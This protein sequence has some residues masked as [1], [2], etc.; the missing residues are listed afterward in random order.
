MA[1]VM[2]SSPTVFMSSSIFS[3]LTRME[4]ESPII[5][6][7]ALSVFAAGAATAAGCAAAGG[8]EAAGG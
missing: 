6:P 2:T 4:L 8:G 3:T 5:E 1:C 7:V